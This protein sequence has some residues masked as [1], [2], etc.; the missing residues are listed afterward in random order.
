MW[1]RG[2]FTK[3]VP[4]HP[5][6]NVAIMST[7]AGIQKYSAF[8]TK[9]EYLEPK[10]CCFVATGTP[11]LSVAEVVDNRCDTKDEKSVSSSSTM[12]QDEDA[13]RQDSEPP[14]QA[15]FQDQP[16]MKGVSIE[17]EKPLK[18]DRKELYRLHVRT[19]H[20][21]FAKQRAMARQGDIPSRLQYYK[22]WTEYPGPR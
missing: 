18:D 14:I 6:K 9:I 12:S 5:A 20:L 21:S 2:K 1:G 19:G 11:E 16:N 15:N 3:T 17:R 8:I 10:I 22:F 13:E 7:K 4:L